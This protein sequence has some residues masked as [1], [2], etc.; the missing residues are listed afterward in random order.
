MAKYRIVTDH[1][2]E[3]RVQFRRNWF[4]RWQECRLTRAGVRYISF[5]DIEQ[6]RAFAIEHSQREPEGTVVAYVEVPRG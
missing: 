5:P 1:N 3:Y 4:C 2:G 6:A